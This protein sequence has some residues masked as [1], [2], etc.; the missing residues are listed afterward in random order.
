MYGEEA[1][2]VA[3]RVGD[4]WPGFQESM[5]PGGCLSYFSFHA[6]FAGGSQ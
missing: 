1:R 4:L 2:L 3:V 6:V 5:A